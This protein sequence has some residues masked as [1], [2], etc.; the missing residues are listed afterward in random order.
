MRTFTE[1]PFATFVTRTI[2]P[3][4]SVLEASRKPARTLHL[5]TAFPVSQW[6]KALRTTNALKRINEEF[7]R[8]KTRLR[9]QRRSGSASA[10]RPA[11][12]RPNHPAQGRRL[13]GSNPTETTMKAHATGPAFQVS[14][15]ELQ[16]MITNCS[17]PDRDANGF[18]TN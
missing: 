8:T 11:A 18:S 2:E 15:L 9:C 16:L 13:A 12:Q 14:D 7:R 17:I 4:G 1:R 6:K 3:I 10:V 5:H